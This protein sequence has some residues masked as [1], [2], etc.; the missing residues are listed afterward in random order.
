MQVEDTRR[1]RAEIGDPAAPART[2]AA[3]L[4]YAEMAVA[5]A[6]SGAALPAAGPPPMR[7]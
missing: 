1:D 4:S 6:W 7:Y 5:I 3:A 2:A